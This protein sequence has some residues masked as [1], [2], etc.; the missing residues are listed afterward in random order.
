MRLVG[1]TTRGRTTI[2]YSYIIA[3]RDGSAAPFRASSEKRAK[4]IYCDDP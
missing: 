4:R 3:I 1:I 2:S